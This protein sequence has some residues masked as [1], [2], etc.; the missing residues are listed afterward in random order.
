[1]A[2]T[3]GDMLHL[4]KDLPHDM[5]VCVMR[6]MPGCVE[7]LPSFQLHDDYLV[8]TLPKTGAYTAIQCVY[9]RS[10]SR[11]DSVWNRARPVD[12]EKFDSVVAFT[13]WATEKN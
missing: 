12:R 10:L 8:M 11:P 6:D 2:M 1:M 9:E 7:Q 4:M 13:I 5:P 3:V